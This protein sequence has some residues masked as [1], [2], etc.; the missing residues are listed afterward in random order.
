MCADGVEGLNNSETLEYRVTIKG[1]WPV[2]TVR[3]GIAGVASRR[4]QAP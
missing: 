2:R 3:V 4:A 1:L